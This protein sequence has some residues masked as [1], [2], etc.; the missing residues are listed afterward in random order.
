MLGNLHPKYRSRHAAIQ[1]IA[2]CRRELI[3]KYSL[4][5]VLQPIVDDIR[6]LVRLHVC[7]LQGHESG[8]YLYMA[9]NMN[10]LQE[11][12]CSLSVGGVEQTVYGTLALVSADNP[13]SNAMGGF[14]ESASAYL[15]CRQCM[16]TTDQTAAEVHIVLHDI[17]GMYNS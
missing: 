1:L 16:G 5:V 7:T 4:N 10:L 6:K 14:K 13:A 17:Q 9:F 8:I 2:L 3:S 12:G 15:P 11:T